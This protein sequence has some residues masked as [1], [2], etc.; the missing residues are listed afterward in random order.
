MQLGLGER[1][2]A[3]DEV[4]PGMIGIR[5]VLSGALA[6]TL[7]AGAIAGDVGPGAAVAAERLVVDRANGAHDALVEL[8]R[9]LE[10]ALEAARRGAARV[11]A[12]DGS[13]DEQ[14]HMAAD[15]ASAADG[16]AA[17]AAVALRRLAA[18]LRA[19]DA[20]AGVVEPPVRTGELPS[21]AGQLR[22][23]AETGAGFAAM[24]RRA[25]GVTAALERALEALDA[26]GLDAA[27]E[28][29]AE[30]RRDHDAIREWDVVLTTLPVWIETTD[31][32]IAAMETI[33]AATRAGDAAAARQ[34]ADDFAAL[35]DEAAVADRA[36]RI[37]VSEGGAAVSAAAL[38]RLA[39]A[40]A[41]V[42][43]ARAEVAAI[44]QTGGR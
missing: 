15:A 39:E 16:M 42:R 9:A 37:A 14:L 13:P 31:A 24:R 5:A 44:L 41:A 2:K 25:D 18:A 3:L 43:Q 23:T 11:V 21:I 27:Q 17:D 33:L 30:A 20:S 10:P 1:A 22:A 8:E 34:A 38:G 40:I 26:G 29:T 32:M 12:G 4:H 7:C 28:A 6:L 35:S 36:L 19:R